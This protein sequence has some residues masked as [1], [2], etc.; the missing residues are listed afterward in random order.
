MGLLMS[1]QERQQHT[2]SRNTTGRERIYV[3]ICEYNDV[4]ICEYMSRVILSFGNTCKYLR[5]IEVGQMSISSAPFLGRHQCYSILIF[6]L[7]II[8]GVGQ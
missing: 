5:V 8:I 3:D 1:L 6:H 4:N 2:S 7:R